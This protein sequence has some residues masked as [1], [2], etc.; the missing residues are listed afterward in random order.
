[1]RK[2]K[3]VFSFC[4]LFLF[5]L[6]FLEVNAQV[7]KTD[8]LIDFQNFQ[9]DEN[10]RNITIEPLQKLWSLLKDI[11]L[12]SPHIET[13]FWGGILNF[14]GITFSNNNNE[15]NATFEPDKLNTNLSLWW[16]K[17]NNWFKINIGVTLGQIIKVALEI[18]IWIWQM[19]IGLLKNI[20]QVL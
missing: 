13:G 9:R 5:F 12:Y 11:K 3:I 20:L 4:V 14:F 18:V 7:G 2:I 1:M 8:N 17:I 10:D 6:F 19:I 16:G 15:N